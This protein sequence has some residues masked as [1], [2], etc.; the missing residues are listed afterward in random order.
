MVFSVFCGPRMG[1]VDSRS[2]LCTGSMSASCL[3]S[4]YIRTNDMA[5]RAL[6]ADA[7]SEYEP[8]QQHG[9]QHQAPRH[10]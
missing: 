10:R 2:G 7:V 1:A 6:C 5:G 9:H 3:R 4:G 8:E